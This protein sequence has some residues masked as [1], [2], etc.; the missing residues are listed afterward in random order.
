MERIQEG[1]VTKKIMRWIP[2]SS[3]LRGRP[4]MK[5]EDDAMHDIQTVK[6]KS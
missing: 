1:E 5:W 4:T 3:R 6:I 2:T